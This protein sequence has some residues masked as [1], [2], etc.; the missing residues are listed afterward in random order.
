MQQH[1]RS[2]NK[3]VTINSLQTF[4]TTFPPSRGHITTSVV[5]DA[6][7]WDASKEER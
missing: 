7:I 1:T 4:D 6:T 3:S 5:K 2:T